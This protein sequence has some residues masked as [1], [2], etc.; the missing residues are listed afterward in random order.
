MDLNEVQKFIAENKDTDEVKAFIGALSAPVDER[1]IIDKYKTSAEFKKDTQS[2]S[3]RK[4]AAALERFQKDHMSKAIEDEIKKRYPDET[5]EQKALREMKAELDSIKTAKS[6]EELRNKAVK[7]L[8]DKKIG[9]EYM[10]FIQAADEDE[11]HERV[12]QFHGL[13]NKSIISAVDER[14]KTHGVNPPV[15]SSSPPAGKITSRE[16]LTGMSQDQ[17]MK[18]IN[19]GRVDIPGLVLTKTN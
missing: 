13:L 4:V 7:M 18:A 2:E 5:S 19:E 3:D 11:L 6:R 15:N 8:N 16:Q 10:D 1:V 12:E 17:M 14:L 9:I